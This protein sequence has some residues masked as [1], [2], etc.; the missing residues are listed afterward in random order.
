MPTTSAGELNVVAISDLGRLG[1]KE[2]PPAAFEWTPLNPLPALLPW[3]AILALLALKP[4][5][6]ISAWWIWL[7]LAVLALVGVVLRAG[8][9]F[10]PEE[11]PDILT[12]V[13]SSLVFGV[14]AAW[15]LAPYLVRAYRF[16]TFLCLELALLGF[17]L[18]T[19]V[20]RQDVLGGN[21][22]RVWMIIPLSVFVLVTGAAMVLAGWKS[23]RRYRPAALLLWAL[24]FLLGIW[25][26]IMTPFFIV[27]LAASRGPIAA[28][29][30][31]TP[32]LIPAAAGFIAVLPFFILASASPFY[33]ERLKSLLH[34]ER[35]SV[36]P[37]LPEAG[38]GSPAQTL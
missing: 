30:F 26:A 19:F 20:L 12:E 17:G 3:L 38:P 6:S 7:P 18:F 35:Q 5:R 4:N 1:A 29:E 24:V 31:L 8:V 14:A 22:G 15:L 28:T 25:L 36:P 27:A 11:V 21:I 23:R 2:G 9:A 10:L 13:F 34:V 16:A 33:R 32:I 37:V